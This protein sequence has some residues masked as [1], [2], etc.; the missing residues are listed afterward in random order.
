MSTPSSFIRL[1]IAP[2]A[3]LREIKRAY[4]R[5]LKSIDPQTQREEFEG[6]RTAYEDALAWARRR[7]GD[8]VEEAPAAVVRHV[9]DDA[10]RADACAV[11]DRES[12]GLTDPADADTPNATAAGDDGEQDV[13]GKDRRTADTDLGSTWT[14]IRE[15]TARLMDP[16]GPSRQ[17]LLDEALADPRL[18][19]LDART[20]FEK[21]LADALHGS[22]A[23]QAALFEA[24]TARFDWTSRRA[25]VAHAHRGAVWVSQVIDQALLWEAQPP[26]IMAARRAALAAAAATERPS[27]R[28]AFLH[29]ESL[30][31][32]SRTFPEWST[33][34]LPPG[35]VEAWSDAYDALPPSWQW[36]M[37][38]RQGVL[39]GLAGIGRIVAGIFRFLRDNI[40]DTWPYRIMGGLLAL[41]MLAT[42][43]GGAFGGK[44]DSAALQASANVMRIAYA[45]AWRA[46]PAAPR[47]AGLDMPVPLERLPELVNRR[48]CRATHAALHRREPRVFDDAAL[49]ASLSTHAQLCAA[50]QMWPAAG[51]PILSCL[52][53]ES[54]WANSQDR[55]QSNA[56]CA[57]AVEK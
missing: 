56:A 10:M 26:R 5:A 29:H 36:R 44:H 30:E 2:S 23:G 4:A 13:T 37:R 33:L 7:Q 21:R 47:A 38:L 15:W 27:H 55:V 49:I 9:A 22:P 34:F 19:H 50:N 18:C 31:A 48:A 40:F 17:Q 20:L 41:I 14:A 8:T 28:D 45:N 1:G 24:A 16:T 39:A 54:W 12:A 3:D 42:V 6:L 51:D 35:R 57:T 53:F 11:A 25:T 32:L 52:A 43:I 46:G